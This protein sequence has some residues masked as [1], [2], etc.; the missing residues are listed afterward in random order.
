MK[1]PLLFLFVCMAADL[2][3]QPGNPNSPTPLG[4]GTLILGSAAL[5]LAYKHKQKKHE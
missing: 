2:L 3:A 1:L 5:Y 4:G